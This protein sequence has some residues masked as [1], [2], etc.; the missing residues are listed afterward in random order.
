MHHNVR[1]YI[2]VKDIQS[3]AHL[4]EEPLK[5]VKNLQ[6]SEEPFLRVK[7]PTIESGAHLHTEEPPEAPP[8]HAR[9]GPSSI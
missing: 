3:G 4:P 2:Q 9:E 1:L 6:T 8:P 7:H 5:R